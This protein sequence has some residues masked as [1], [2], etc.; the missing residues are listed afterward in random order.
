M[1][2]DETLF[3]AINDLSDR[4]A[5]LDAFMIAVSDPDRWLLPIVLLA[6]F[7]AWRRPRE[8]L[9]GG[10]LLAVVIGL[11]DLIGAQLK[12][13]VARPRPCQVLDHVRELIG[14]GG[15]MSFPSNHAVN[16]AAA[17]A[18]FHGLYPKT[19]WIGWPLV[20][21]VGFSRVYLGAHYVTDVLG[22]WVL[23]GLFGFGAAF[24]LN[25]FYLRR[26]PPPR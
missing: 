16:T 3:H 4:S 12:A 8:A 24:L 26:Y 21:I 6:G 18:F 13:L 11:G 2:W 25:R 1:N 14:C 17:A 15:A 22:G 10:P 9:A 7:W 19:A 20:G 23:G 5:L